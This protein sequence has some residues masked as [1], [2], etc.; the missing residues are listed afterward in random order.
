MSRERFSGKTVGEVWVEASEGLTEAG[1]SGSSV[2]HS[3]D[4]QAEGCAIPHPTDFS[5]SGRMEDPHDMVTGF[6]QTER[7]KREQ[8]RCPNAFLW[9]SPRSSTSLY[10]HF[11]LLT[12]V[13]PIQWGMGIPKGKARTWDSLEG[14]LWGWLLQ[15]KV[16]M[17]KKKNLSI[18]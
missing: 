11:L 10:P 9:P 6:Y 7:P 3:Y 13:S 14:I 18:H 16:T 15:S 8:G 2:T 17:T 12:W 1:R 5:V 4:W